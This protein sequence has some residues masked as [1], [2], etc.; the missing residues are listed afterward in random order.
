M[1]RTGNPRE[2]RLRL[3]PAAGFGIGTRLECFWRDIPGRGEAQRCGP[4]ARWQRWPKGMGFFQDRPAAISRQQWSWGWGFSNTRSVFFS[5]MS[6]SFIMFHHVYRILFIIIIK[7]CFFPWVFQVS[8]LISTSLF[9]PSMVSPLWF[10]RWPGSS[11]K[12]IAT[13]GHC[14][15]CTAAQGSGWQGALV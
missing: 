11:I 15:G 8:S 9:F 7:P 2:V 14:F 13:G 3:Q 6:N 5:P 4:W 12:A 1:S 10:L